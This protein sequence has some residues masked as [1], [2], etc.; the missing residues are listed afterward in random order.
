MTHTSQSM[1]KPAS[2]GSAWRPDGRR[3]SSR[4]PGLRAPGPK[5]RGGTSRPPAPQR[6]LVIRSLIAVPDAHDSES[7]RYQT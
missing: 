4:H 3:P 6:E 2:D 7:G 5:T 1:S